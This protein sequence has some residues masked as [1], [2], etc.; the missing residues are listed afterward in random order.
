M[1]REVAYGRIAKAERKDRHLKVAEYYE[2]EAPVEA[3]AVIASHYMSA[4]EAGPE[5]ELA[6]KARGALVNAA[7]RASELKSFAQALS[8]V[9]QA[10]DLGGFELASFGD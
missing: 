4:Y 10:L 6:D 3:A 7:Q 8:L 2:H 9:E 1:I 5:D